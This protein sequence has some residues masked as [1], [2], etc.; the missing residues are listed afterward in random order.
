MCGIVGYVG[1]KSA[2]PIVL[3]GLERLEYRGYDSAGFA[4]H[5]DSD[6]VIQRNVGPVR[7]LIEASKHLGKKE[8]QGIAHTRWATHGAPSEVNAHPHVAGNI[9]IVHNGIIENYSQIKEYLLA[10]AVHFSS[11]TDT[12]VFAQLIEY[13]RKCL[14]SSNPALSAE[15]II[16]TAIEFSMKEVEGEYS[17]LV[18]DKSIPG[19]IYGVQNGAPLVVSRFKD[20]CMIASDVQ[21]IL[22]YHNEVC[23][24]PRGR[25]FVASSD[26]LF[27]NDLKHELIE[28]QSVHSGKAEFES[29]MMKEIFEQPTAVSDSLNRA[30]LPSQT[31][32]HHALWKNAQR[33]TLIACGTSYHAALTA[34]YLFEKWAQLECDVEIASEFRYRSPKFG[35][36]HAVGIISQSGETADSLAAL[37]LAHRAGVRTFSICNVPSSTLSRETEILYPTHAGPEIGVASSKAFTSQLSV[38][39]KLVLEVAQ[40]R[41]QGLGPK[42]LKELESL[43]Q[44]LSSVLEGAD[45]MLRIGKALKDQRMVL[46]I[47][48]GTSYPIALEGALKFKE[49][50][51]IPSEGFAAGELK[52]G[53]IAYID[54][55][56][57]VIVL[58]PRDEWYS[59]TVSN[60]EEI[61][62][63]GG[64]LIVIGTEFRDR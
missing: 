3:D 61:R 15:S 43:P 50:T 10:K 18:M 36:N 37:R 5:S 47:G 57:S 8:T 11:D 59:K 12:E 55:K 62:A 6:F 56:V 28:C 4:L 25:F 49:L 63:R 46:F 32:A 58:A 29:F 1:Q 14:A 51:Y 42:M 45:K 53:P 34:K 31:E 41:G 24:L 13:N 9:V 44:A 19:K 38:L 48:R 23:F 22:P 21:A 17:I 2:L 27:G 40:I 16:Q 52:H 64:H 33:L 54:P 20:G 30:F 35:K 39:C 26:G 60:L 7:E